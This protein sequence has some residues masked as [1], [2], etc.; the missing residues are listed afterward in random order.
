MGSGSF[1]R[2]VHIAVISAAL[3]VLAY[4]ATLP[5]A[6]PDPA[7]LILP[8]TLLLAGAAFLWWRG[9]GKPGANFRRHCAAHR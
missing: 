8:L 3:L 4:A 7:G 9:A 5:D 2:F 6:D 1:H